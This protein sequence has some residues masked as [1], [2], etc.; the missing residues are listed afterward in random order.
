M[1]KSVTLQV[2]DSSSIRVTIYYLTELQKYQCEAWLEIEEVVQ[3]R[4]C[5]PV[6]DI[7][8]WTLI[9]RECDWLFM[10]TSAALVEDLT[11]ACLRI[12]DKVKKTD[13]DVSR[14]MEF[15]SLYKFFDGYMNLAIWKD[16]E[17]RKAIADFEDK[18]PVVNE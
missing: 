12:V 6:R 3:E 16:L 9:K 10:S 7:A 1:T 13:T 5:D 17:D 2:S 15:P 14:G 18:Y 8:G 11:L 4:E